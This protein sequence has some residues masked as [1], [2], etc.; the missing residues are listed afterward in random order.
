M[1]KQKGIVYEHGINDMS[2]EWM[3]QN[4]KIYILWRNMIKRVYDEKTYETHPKYINC[5]IC[6]EWHWL[7]KFAEDIMKIENYEK[8]INND[9]KYHLDKDI[10][11]NGKNKEY[12]LENCI[13]ALY[14]EN[15]KQAVKTR[16]ND[17][18]KGEN[19]IFY[20]VHRYGE[21]NPMYGKHHT[22]ET[23]KNLSELN[24]GSNHPR[25]KKVAKYDKQM[26]LIKIWDYAKQVAE[27][28]GW[29]YET[30][31]CHLIG[32]GSNEYKG[33]IWMYLKNE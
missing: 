3:K 4:K 28:F 23:R 15:I 26:N 5:T 8:W 24:K 10:R 18:L 20:N 21:D 33:F 22:E 11:S 6:L 13:F 30:F 17:Y 31:R 16:N 12:C 9:R 2:C 19:N 25:A 27:E 14:D 1:K 7:S 29:N 32:K